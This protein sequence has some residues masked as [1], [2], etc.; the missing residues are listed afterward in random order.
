METIVA[1]DMGKFKSVVCY[2]NRENHRRSDT[3]FVHKTIK[4]AY[5]PQFADSALAKTPCCLIGQS[6]IP[7]RINRRSTHIGMA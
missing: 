2:L 1:M 4:T 7:F 6:L 5:S 3:L